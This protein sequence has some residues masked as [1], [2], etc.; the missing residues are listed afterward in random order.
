ML[1]SGGDEPPMVNRVLVNLGS[2]STGSTVPPNLLPVELCLP[3]LTEEVKPADVAT[4]RR[5]FT[6]PS[7]KRKVLPHPT[8]PTKSP[9]SKL[10]GRGSGVG[11]V[12]HDHIS[13]V[14]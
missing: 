10:D 3:T 7:K 6:S 2:D 14:S 1:K 11:G 9:K 8:N 5:S 13:G 12:S 4:P